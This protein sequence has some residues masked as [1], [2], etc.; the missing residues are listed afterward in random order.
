MIF[1]FWVR[2]FYNHGKI[3]S[4]V[5]KLAMTET[6]AQ[7]DSSS[8]PRTRMRSVMTLELHSDIAHDY[9]RAHIPPEPDAKSQPGLLEFSRQVRGGIYRRVP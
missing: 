3:L 7:T 9:L 5:R 2:D 8:K 1:A 6:Q 4:L